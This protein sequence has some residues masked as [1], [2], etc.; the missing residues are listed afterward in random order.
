MK[1]QESVMLP[2]AYEQP[3]DTYKVPDDINVALLHTI[4]AVTALRDVMIRE[5]ETLEK[6]N[7]RAFMAMQDE[8]LEVARRYDVLVSTLMGR[9]GDIKAAD[10]KLKQQLERLQESFGETAKLNRERIER[11]RNATKLLGDRIMKCARQEAETMTQFAY[12]SNGKMQRGGK[13]SIG[14]DERA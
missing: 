7:T 6:S 13:A 5:N 11:M 2:K 3:A 9:A 8:K 4:I 14:T 12:G 10:P 1:P